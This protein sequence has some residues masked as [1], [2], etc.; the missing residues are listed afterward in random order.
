[1]LIYPGRLSSGGLELR[2]PGA[3]SRY[4]RVYLGIT[5]G[6]SWA[7]QEFRD[8]VE[9]DRATPDRYP[10]FGIIVVRKKRETW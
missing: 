8:K 6:A 7:K 9:E 1:M 4:P 10:E 3:C 5:F 2:L